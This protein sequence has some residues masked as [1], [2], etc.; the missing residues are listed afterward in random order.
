MNEKLGTYGLISTNIF[1]GDT[2]AIERISREFVEDRSRDHVAYCEARFC[3]H[4]LLSP[5]SEGKSN[6]IESNGTEASATTAAA[7][8]STV[9]VTSTAAAAIPSTTSSNG[10]EREVTLDDIMEAVLRGIA[11]G[12]KNCP[13]TKVRLLLCCIRGMPRKCHAVHNV[14]SF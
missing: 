7:T 4:L 2:A 3:P 6:T 12:E 9:A 8:S 14:V 5:P 10:I 13:G 11:Q 1:R